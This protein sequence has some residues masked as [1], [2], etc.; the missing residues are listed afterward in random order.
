MENQEVGKRLARFL[1]QASRPVNQPQH[2][3]T[4]SIQNVFTLLGLLSPGKGGSQ[5]A[6]V[7]P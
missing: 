7:K 4:Q 6:L 1:P 5:T 3:D 2:L